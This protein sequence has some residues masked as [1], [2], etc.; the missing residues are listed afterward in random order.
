M[1][2]TNLETILYLHHKIPNTPIPK[3]STNPVTWWLFPDTSF[4]LVPWYILLFLIGRTICCSPPVTSPTPF[5]PALYNIVGNSS[6]KLLDKYSTIIL[7]PNSLSHLIWR[8]SMS[9]NTLVVL[10]S[11]ALLFLVCG[12]RQTTRVCRLS[13]TNIH[14]TH[15]ALFFCLRAHMRPQLSSAFC[16]GAVDL[17]L[18]SLPLRNKSEAIDG[19][20]GNREA[21][22]NTR[23]P[24]ENFPDSLS[25]CSLLSFMLREKNSICLRLSSLNF[26]WIAINSASLL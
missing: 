19:K 16:S 8:I 12:T 9:Q 18:S 7:Q 24:P 21:T 4:A 13:Q 20:K 23:T 26:S 6:R 22:T 11:I 14:H 17:G 2:N 3:D 10:L 15:D 5:D 25:G 1:T